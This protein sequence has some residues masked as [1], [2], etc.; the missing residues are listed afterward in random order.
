M[1]RTDLDDVRDALAHI[2]LGEED[3]SAEDLAELDRRA[4]DLA[5]GRVAGVRHADVQRGL[6][7][8]E[9]LGR[10]AG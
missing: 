7:G 3:L 9:R 10:K 1:S 4:E 2:P 6:D 5:S 8:L